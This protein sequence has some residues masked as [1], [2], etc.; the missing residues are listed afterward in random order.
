MSVFISTFFAFLYCC[1]A[2]PT[3]KDWI[4]KDVCIIG[5]GASGTY[6][7][8]RLQQLGVDVAL[9]EKQAKLG[10]MVTNRENW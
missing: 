5:G 7:A 10:G 2:F 8:V 4:E 9:V 6:A 1:S 3:T